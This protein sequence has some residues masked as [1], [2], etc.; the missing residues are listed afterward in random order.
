MFSCAIASILSKNFRLFQNRPFLVEPEG[1]ISIG[2]AKVGGF[3]IPAKSFSILF[4]ENLKLFAEW[5][6]R[7]PIVKWLLMTYD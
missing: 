3:P 2:D 1:F 6:V 7:K 4:Q 5:K